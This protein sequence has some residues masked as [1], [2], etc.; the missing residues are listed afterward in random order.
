M[1]QKVILV[2]VI[3]N[4]KVFYCIACSSNSCSVGLISFDI[5]SVIVSLISTLLFVG[6]IIYSIFFNK[7]TENVSR[8]V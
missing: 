3:T 5:T 1:I 6:I 2:L 7:K 8:D 4:L